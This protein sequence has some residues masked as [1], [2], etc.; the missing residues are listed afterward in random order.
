LTTGGFRDGAGITSLAFSPDGKLLASGS[1][2]AKLRVWEV[3]TGKELF[4]IRRAGSGGIAFAPDG[5]LL[6]SAEFEGT[7]AIIHLLDVA[8]GKERSRFVVPSGPRR[9]GEEWP[10]CFAFSPDGKLLSCG[11]VDATARIFEVATG[12]ELQQLLHPP[13]SVCSVAFS[14]DGKILAS[15]THYLH[16]R[17]WDA[18][19]GKLLTELKGHG[20]GVLSLAFSQDGRSLVS[21]SYDR[22]IRLWQVPT[23][24]QLLLFRGH[25]GP[26]D[27]VAF[28]A[29]GKMVVSGSSDSTVRLWEV[30]TAKERRCLVGHQAKIMSLAFSP[31]SRTFATGSYDTT[32]LLWEAR[33]PIK[34]DHG[35][36]ANITGQ[37]LEALWSDLAGDAPRAFDAMCLLATAPK[38]AI[39]LLQER[40]PPILALDGARLSQLIGNLDSELF[41]TRE[42]AT[43]EL[44]KLAYL[45]EPELR[46]VLSARPSPEMRSRLEQLLE[47]LNGPVPAAHWRALRALEVLEN[48]G[49]PEAERLLQTLANGPLMTRFTLESRAA[50]HRLSRR[51]GTMP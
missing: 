12:K 3:A 7:K 13:F 10:L 45:V 43:R 48:I 31:D 6:A 35:V 27:A 39:A 47:R 11:C 2:E 18:A 40:L 32:I 19:T 9:R 4:Q 23:G 42:Q 44:E 37:Q 21:A 26:V 5:K 51:L 38:Q 25:D 15:G 29:D 41:Q 36:G 14:P 50:L 17:L 34:K 16:V 24:A 33:V 22:T 1:T 8:T 28:S 30:A 46:K 20:G 49:T